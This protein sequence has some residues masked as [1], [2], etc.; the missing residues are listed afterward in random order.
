MVSDEDQGEIRGSQFVFGGSRVSGNSNRAA[1]LK[2]ASSLSLGSLQTANRHHSTLKG[3]CQQDRKLERLIFGQLEPNRT[4]ARL[5][6]KQAPAEPIAYMI[7]SSLFCRVV[8]V[9]QC[10]L[11]LGES[12]G[13]K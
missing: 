9:K 10:R 3:D 1:H 11:V 7:L 6:G 2:R 12:G 4:E 8:P 5:P 13:R